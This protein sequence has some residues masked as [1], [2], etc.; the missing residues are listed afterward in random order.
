MGA[1]LKTQILP[2]LSE[3]KPP[4][5]DPKDIPSMNRGAKNVFC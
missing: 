5:L 3:K 2:N 4:K 1:F